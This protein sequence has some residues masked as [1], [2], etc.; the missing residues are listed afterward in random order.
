MG[1]TIDFVEA[2]LRLRPSIETN[3]SDD[4][5]GAFR[6]GARLALSTIELKACAL[7]ELIRSLEQSGHDVSALDAQLA[8]LKMLVLLAGVALDSLLGSA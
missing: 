6:A 3:R 5:M 8:E 1:I 7:E 4:M 2:A